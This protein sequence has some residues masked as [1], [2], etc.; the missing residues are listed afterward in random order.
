MHI[1]TVSRPKKAK[2]PEGY[3]GDAGVSPSRT[4]PRYSCEKCDTK[5]KDNEETCS[6]CGHE[7]CDGCL[8]TSPTRTRKPGEEAAVQSV[9]ERMRKLE[10][11]PQA[12]AA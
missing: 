6:S 5:F 4:R 3:P 1:L 9:E 12:S 7:K 11:S 2:Y 10:V 8:R